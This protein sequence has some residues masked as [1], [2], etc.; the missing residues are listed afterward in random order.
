MVPNPLTSARPIRHAAAIC[1]LTLSALP[2]GAQ[3][4]TMRV[5]WLAGCWEAR[6]GARTTFEMWSPPAGGMLVGAG[7]TVV[8][9]RQRGHEHLRLH[10]AGDTLV[11]TAIP[12]GQIETEFKSTSLTD[13][14]FVVENK[15]HDFPQRITYRLTGADSLVVRVEGPA[16]NGTRRFSLKF[17]RTDC[18]A[19]SP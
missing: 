5:N 17:A 16:P 9:G 4:A 15:A 1:A 19:A 13:S 7:R 18:S 6:D 12:S 10:A 14:S 3:D 11:Y 2:A 8:D